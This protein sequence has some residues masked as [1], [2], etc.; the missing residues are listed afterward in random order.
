MVAFIPFQIAISSCNPTRSDQLV[1]NVHSVLY[2][3]L[4]HGEISLSAAQ[5]IALNVQPLLE[6]STKNRSLVAKL[7]NLHNNPVVQRFPVYKVLIEQLETRFNNVEKLVHSGWIDLTTHRLLI[8]SLRADANAL[9]ELHADMDEPIR[10]DSVQKIGS[11]SDGKSS[12]GDRFGKLSRLSPLKWPS[13][14]PVATPVR[15]GSKVLDAARPEIPKNE[16]VQVPEH[17][18]S[19]ATDAGKYSLPINVTVEENRVNQGINGLTT[20]TEIPKHPVQRNHNDLRSNATEALVNASAT[21]PVNVVVAKDASKVN[22]ETREKVFEFLLKGKN[23]NP[24]EKSAQASAIPIATDG[25]GV[26]REIGAGTGKANNLRFGHGLN[27]GL[28]GTAQIAGLHLAGGLAGGMSMRREN[29]DID[30]NYGDDYDD[31]GDDYGDD[32]DD[33]DDE[34]LI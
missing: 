22:P 31:Y 16:P 25:K 4:R 1:Q 10:D 17:L 30:Y 18:D 6:P 23:P 32:Y 12:F 29:H 11:I 34:Y 8:D 13:S 19:K 21:L 5:R 33:F 24:S 7:R 3:E 26:N 2:D 15:Q 27:M 9:T 28:G 14:S 20:I